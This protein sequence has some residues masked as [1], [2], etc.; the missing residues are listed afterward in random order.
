MTTDPDDNCEEDIDD[1]E[2]PD[3]SDLTGQEDGDVYPCPYCGEEVY[4]DAIR[5]PHCQRYVSAADGRPSAFWRW[6]VVILLLGGAAVLIR[7]LMK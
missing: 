2:M 1:R 3:E 6:V 7:A 5:C 4:E